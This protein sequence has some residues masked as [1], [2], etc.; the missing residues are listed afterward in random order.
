MSAEGDAVEPTAVDAAAPAP[1]EAAEPMDVMT[2]LQIV[3][4]TS[5]VHD[6]LARGLH[7]AAKALDRRQAHL[8]VLASNCT[9]AAY[10]KLVEAL[11]AEHSIPLITVDDNKKLG[12]WAGLCKIDKEG[13]ARKVVG[14]SCVVV[15]DFGKDTPA[16]DVLM[17]YFRTKSQ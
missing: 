17:E 3:L 11:C 2:A 12:E 5:L 7:E 4:K 16:R 1:V 14:A 10:L 13:N 6:G 15:K 8:C 9:E